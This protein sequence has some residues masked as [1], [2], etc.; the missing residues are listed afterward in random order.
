VKSLLFFLAFIAVATA[1]MLLAPRVIGRALTGTEF[2]AIALPIGAVLARLSLL[3]HRRERR[4]VE[5]MRDSAL[6]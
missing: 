1:V 2:A 4:K 6:W 5:E 3:A